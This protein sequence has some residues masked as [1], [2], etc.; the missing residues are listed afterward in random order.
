[1]AKSN[2]TKN[3]KTIL[4][5]DPAILKEFQDFFKSKT[6][7]KKTEKV[8]TSEVSQHGGALTTTASAINNMIGAYNPDDIRIDTYN[9]MRRH[10]QLQMGLKVIKLPIIGQQ[11]TT[12]CDD[13]DIAEFIDQLLRPLWYNLLT[14]T[15]TAIDYGFSAHE[16]VYEYK[17][18]ELYR[19]Y[20]KKAFFKNNSVIWKKFKSLYPD[21]VNIILDE[22]ENFYGISQVNQGRAINISKDKSFVFTHDKGDSFGN[23]FGVSRLKPCYDTW[24]Y[25]QNLIMFMLSYYER[26]GSPPIIV[27]FPPGQSKRGTDN[28]DTALEIGKSLM[29]ESVVAISSKTYENTPPQW[30]L[31]YLTDDKRGEMF[32]SGLTFLENKMLRGLFVPERTVTQDSS[33]KAGSY[34]LSQTH[35]DMFM[36]GEEAL[37]VDIENQ[38]NKYVVRRLIEYN[39]GYKAPQ[40]F[41]K[42]ERITDA[43]KK[44]LKD[45]FME[46]IKNG[47]AI[48]AAREIADIVGV[49]LE[50]DGNTSNNIK[51]INKEKHD[52]TKD[53]NI[54]I[55]T[56]KKIDKVNTIEDTKKKLGE[57]TWWRSPNEFEDVKLL[58]DIE[59]RMNIVENSFI[60]VLINDV[61]I[62]QREI[63]L[64]KV[65]KILSEKGS[66]EDIWYQKIDNNISESII[67]FQPLRNKMLNLMSDYMKESFIFG[68]ESAL[69]ELKIDSK[70]SV[71]REDKVFISD[72]SRSIVDKYFANMKY[73]VELIML[74]AVSENKTNL[75][76]ENDIK[77]SF[78]IIKDR[79]LKN[80]VTTESLLFLNIG[81]RKIM[82]DYIK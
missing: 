54:S 80:I 63:I 45:V 43:K 11:W 48:P 26:K 22:K 17:D 67:L 6:K 14:S 72:R 55:T 36:L 60:E 68:Q 1:M 7:S 53:N 52:N 51:N 15:L 82:K 46:M 65:D 25:Y 38:I 34:S 57:N 40:C 41:V 3:L 2:K 29:S 10:P 18:L 8:D 19:R 12:I 9:L 37:L 44:F 81:R 79:D 59:N 4:E 35:A 61:W 39:F 33:S 50:D 74:S 5:E 28:A 24:Y 13:K 30:D 58:T 78:D 69:L 16:I 70:Y 75:D 32:L 76:I 23:L 56:D 64:K 21:T 47:N 31:N 42:I 20:E 71:D 66:V 77:R 73:S 27:K 62:K 49:P